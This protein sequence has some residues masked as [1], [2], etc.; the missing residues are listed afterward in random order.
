MPDSRDSRSRIVS[1][2]LLRGI[3]MLL[4]VI[5]H[6]RNY[7]ATT[8]ALPEDLAEP[9]LALFLTRWI[10]HFCAPVFVFLAGTSAFLHQRNAGMDIPELRRFLLS[11]GVWL[12]AAEFLLINPFWPL[13]MDGY[14]LAQVIW[15]IGWSM[16]ALGL[17][18]PLGRRNLFLL[19]LVIVLGHNLLDGISSASFGALAPLWI[20]LHEENVI[21]L[22]DNWNIYA[23][24]PLLPWIGTMLLGYAFGGLLADDVRWQQHAFRIGLGAVAGFLLLRGFNIY[25]NPADWVAG[26]DAA[27]T[28][29][30]FLNVEKYPPSLQYLLMTLGPAL[31]LMPLLEKVS[32]A[33]TRAV[34][35]FGRVPFFFY[36]LHF[37]LIYVIAIGW[38]LAAYG[39]AF[40]WFRGEAAFPTEFSPSLPLTYLVALLVIFLLYPACIRYARFKRE[41]R[42]LKWLSYI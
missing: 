19:G 34:S 3:V 10:T 8:P 1:V 26:K 15:A 9:G 33:W 23:A 7:F 31:L 6:V 12:V 13:W 17:L 5:D 30:N 2:D 28:L 16:I 36:V 4:M 22:T 29:V 38:N 41:R 20:I 32:G 11:R 25:G 24:Y 39:K 18:L 35:V 21:A 42:D 27:A 37:A 40:W 14:L